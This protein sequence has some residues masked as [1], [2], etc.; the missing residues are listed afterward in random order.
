MPNDFIKFW[1]LTTC[2][3]CKK[4]KQFLDDCGVSYDL[5]YV[6]KLEGEE[7]KQTIEEVKKHNSALSF[8]T[9]LVGDTVVVGFNEAD[10]K[11]ALKL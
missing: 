8:P 2:I 6:D 4:A 9:I 1:G 5:T 10:L 11:A 3:H 7:R